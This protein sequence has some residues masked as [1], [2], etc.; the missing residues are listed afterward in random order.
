MA[1]MKD[2]KDTIPQTNREGN[3]GDSPTNLSQKTLQN[4]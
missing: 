3:R 1:R 4:W 2:M